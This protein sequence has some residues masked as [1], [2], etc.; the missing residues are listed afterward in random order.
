MFPSTPH[1]SIQAQNSIQQI[2]ALKNS[3]RY[4]GRKLPEKIVKEL[5]LAT[6]LITE[7]TS[8][9]SLQAI[10]CW[11]MALKAHEFYARGCVQV[12]I[13]KSICDNDTD[14]AVHA[15][16]E[17]TLERYRHLIPKIKIAALN[18]RSAAQEFEKNS[19]ENQVK[20][21][22]KALTLCEAYVT[23]LMIQELP[24]SDVQRNSIG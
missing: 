19:D 15:Q 9:V 13:M 4:S 2:E 1:L 20:I 11:E 18:V 14:I 17:E 12:E 10:P 23:E 16:D 3:V 5:D 7:K 24:H 8:T 6:I 22:K 21:A